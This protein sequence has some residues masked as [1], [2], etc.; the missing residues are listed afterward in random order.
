MASRRIFHC[1]GVAAA[2]TCA[3]G[4]AAAIELSASERAGKRIF[5]EGRSATGSSI[6]ARVGAGDTAMPGTVVPCANC[7]GADGRGR[8]EGGVR[9]SDI[10]WR[11]LATP[12]GQRLESG[13]E[14]PAY[15]AASLARAV[16]HGVDPAG[17][18]LDPAMPRFVMSARDLEDLTAY[19]KRLEDD[20][21]PGLLED[22]LRLGTLQPASG[23][24][25]ELGGTVTAVLRGAIDAV[26]ADGGI[27]GRRVELIVADA[28]SDAAAGEAALRR[29]VEQDK[30]FAVLAP[31]AP[32]LDGRLGELADAA[33]I[34]LVGP[35]AQLASGGGRFVFDPLPGLGEQLGA[36]G[37]YAATTLKLGNP[38]AAIVHPDDRRSASLATALAE[39]LGRRGWSQVRAYA[40]APG[41][42]DAAGAGTALAGQGA[43]AVFFVGRDD[44]FGALAAQK[45]VQKSAPWLFAAATQVGPAALKLAP[46]QAERVFVAYPTLPQDWSPQGAGLLRAMRE[47][48]GVGERH[49]AFQVGAYAAALVM[50]EGLKRAGRDASRE[51][52]VAALENLHG[53]QTGL[54]PAIG[55]GPGQ[56]VGAPGAHIVAVDAA[57]R[58]FRPT[59]RYVRLDTT[60]E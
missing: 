29:L 46:A 24:L 25:A 32:A 35:L 8:R 33:R 4:T 15:D 36:L 19:L 54:T 23:P 50:I 55:F 43:K 7:H 42:F 20:R 34:P 49:P 6:A 27:H 56:R 52:L 28:G 9:P 38:P 13:R 5:L 44:D 40:Y 16:S 21:D 45:S 60:Q 58:T 53:F 22:V 30:V 3:A 47:R 17:N 11:R 39:R 48:S 12:Y 1:L 31:L 14:H 26:N 18:R 41:A 10:T 51:K 57:K 2:L 37:E 59:G